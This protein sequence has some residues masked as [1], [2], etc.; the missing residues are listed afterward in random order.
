MACLVGT[1]QIGF[2]RSVLSPPKRTPRF[3]PRIPQ[4]KGIREVSHASPPRGRPR[5]FLSGL[6][7]GSHGMTPGSA[8]LAPGR[9]RGQDRAS[10]GD[11]YQD[12]QSPC[13]PAG[14]QGEE[15]LGVEAVVASEILS[16][17]VEGILMTTL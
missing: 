15:L 1:I 9:F 13:P 2:K 12:T 17:S 3:E 16:H 5:G 4:M 10:E 14:E 8:L 6:L 11:R 7:L